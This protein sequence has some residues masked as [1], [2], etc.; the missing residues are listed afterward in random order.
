M[1]LEQID[2]Y[3][4]ELVSQTQ[5]LTELLATN[6]TKRSILQKQLERKEGKLERLETIKKLYDQY[7]EA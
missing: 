5:T 3:I 7:R 1:D 4:A 6:A 2:T